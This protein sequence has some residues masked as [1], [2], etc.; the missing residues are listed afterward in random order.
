MSFSSFHVALLSEKKAQSVFSGRLD[1]AA[2]AA[3]AS[4]LF[5][6]PTFTHI[7]RFLT[8][9]TLSP[10]LP[11]SSQRQASN[12][13]NNSKSLVSSSEFFLVIKKSLS[14]KILKEVLWLK[15]LSI[16]LLK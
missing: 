16:Q 3:A 15:S 9:A 6:F 4:A 7:W 5:M 12:R 1:T 13:K 8:A 2:A 14:E 10:H 11:D